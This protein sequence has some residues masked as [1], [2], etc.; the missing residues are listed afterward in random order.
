MFLRRNACKLSAAQQGQ[1]KKAVSRKRRDWTKGALAAIPAGM[2][3]LSLTV[4]DLRSLGRGIFA[5][6]L[7]PPL[8]S[9]WRAGQ[10]VMLRPVAWGLEM[11]RA[12][13]FSVAGLDAQGLVCFFQVA[14]RGTERLTRLKAGDEVHAWGPLGNGFASEP[15]TPT[16]LL[17][18]GIGIA[19]FVGY[20]LQHPMPCNLTLL[21]GHR[22]SEDSYPLKAL[23][24]R[25]NV[26]SI[27][28]NGPADVERFIVR[29][30]QR[31]AEYAGGL[32]LACGPKPLLRTVREYAVENGARV[33]LS[34]EERM[35]CGVGACLGCVV[36]STEAW[37][38]PEKRQRPVPS[39]TCGPVFW[40][41]Q[42]LLDETPASQKGRP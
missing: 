22:A 34:L 40:A 10:F 12:R 32:T 1:M 3:A 11:L 33:Q 39:C 6:T 36:T 7:S 2:S 18:G 5:L 19:P 24:G 16:L 37:P 38:V 28:D 26:E 27:Q 23:R 8:W 35:A 42:I 20:A 29:L 17:A 14:G 31:M 21:F 15:D 25:I 41:D 30:K 9:D 4:L 13:P